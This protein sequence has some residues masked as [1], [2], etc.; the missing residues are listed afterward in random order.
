MKV[1]CRGSN[2]KSQ[3]LAKNIALYCARK[4][5]SARLARTLTVTIKFEKDLKGIEG[6]C[7][8]LDEDFRP[9]D[10]IIR[11]SDNIPL[12]KQLKCICHEMVHVKQYAR[13]EMKQMFRPYGTT[14]YMGQYYSDDMDY[15]EQPWEIEAYGREPGLYTNWV[16]SNNYVND[17]ELDTRL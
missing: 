14:R 1:Y 15:W 10:F 4:L 7:E 8:W 16:D 13:D 17:P 11:I 2:R 9:K 12:A 3:K 5:M 6:D